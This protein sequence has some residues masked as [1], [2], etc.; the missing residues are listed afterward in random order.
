MAREECINWKLISQS[1]DSTDP[2]TDVT[3]RTE[4]TPTEIIYF[5]G[6]KSEFSNFFECPDNC[7]Y[8]LYGNSFSTTESA[9][10]FRKA[11]FFGDF[12][13]AGNL[14]CKSGIM[15]KETSKKIKRHQEWQSDADS[16]IQETQWKQIKCHETTNIL[17]EKARSC[18]HFR[19]ALAQSGQKKTGGRH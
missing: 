6:A 4:T 12:D 1:S 8:N 9:Y 2:F 15:A 5:K 18:S 17:S 16:Q 13:T 3:S 14:K 11:L 19:E 10:Q 7:S